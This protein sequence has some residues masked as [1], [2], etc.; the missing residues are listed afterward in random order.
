MSSRRCGSAKLNLVGGW[1]WR[2]R[3]LGGGRVGGALQRHPWAWCLLGLFVRHTTHAWNKLD[4]ERCGADDA[5]LAVPRCSSAC[6]LVNNPPPSALAPSP[7]PRHPATPCP[8]WFKPD[9]IS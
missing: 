5:V 2:S 7:P 6:V 3:W 4:G 9:A 8:A 1:R